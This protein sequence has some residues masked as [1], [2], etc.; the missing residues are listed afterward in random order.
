MIRE[1]TTNLKTQTAQHTFYKFKG[2]YIEGSEKRILETRAV[3]PEKARSNFMHQL[4]R[5]Y[6]M[7]LIKMIEHIRQGHGT[8]KV[9]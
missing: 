7:P 6:N 3:S 2:T 9:E 5:I 8:L 1:H 4:S